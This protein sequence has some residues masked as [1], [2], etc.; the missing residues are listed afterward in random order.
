MSEGFP[1]TDCKIWIGVSF[2]TLCQCSQSDF[3]KYLPPSWFIYLD[4]CHIY[5]FSDHQT[6]VH[7]KQ[8]I[9]VNAKCSSLNYP[10]IY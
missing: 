3:E 7:I 1:K 9:H 2:M 10:F 6:N 4:I 8:E 5:M